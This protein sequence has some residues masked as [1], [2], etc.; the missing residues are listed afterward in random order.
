MKALRANLHSQLFFI[1]LFLAA[2][3][4][5][6]FSFTRVPHLLETAD[7]NAR[8]VWASIDVNGHHQGDAHLIQSAGATVLI[9]AGSELDFGKLSPFLERFAIESLDFA[10]VTHPHF[11]HYGGF[12]KMLESRF[13]IKKLFI[14]TE[15]LSFCK[16]EAPWGCRPD[17]L[18][19][20]THLAKLNGTE[21][22]DRRELLTI[23]LDRATTLDIV[24]NFSYK[25]GPIENG[26]INDSSLVLA[27]NAH[28]TKVLFT[29][30]ANRAL[31]VYL[32]NSHLASR[33]YDILKAPHHGT[34]GLPDNGF[35]VATG[36]RIFVVPSPKELWHSDRSK[37]LREFTKDHQIKTLVNGE[38]GHVLVHFFDNGAFRISNVRETRSFKEW[39]KD[40][41][42][43]RR[44]PPLKI[45]R[46]SF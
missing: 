35:F 15:G 22:I 18:T 34:E 1:F 23:T 6:W 41:L 46:Q 31:G 26:D 10:I 32:T 29:G 36:A 13:P 24:A 28:G 8:V 44:N 2:A 14:D 21:I 16:D 42:L 33:R 3:Y 11:D 9:D 12:I 5:G 19:K 45:S 4:L 30:D 38:V 37:R 25:T 27:L 7:G 40:Q 43:L 17:D 20:I 39:L